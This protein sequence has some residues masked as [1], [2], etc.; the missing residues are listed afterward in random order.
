MGFSGKNIPAFLDR[1]TNIRSDY[2]R[3]AEFILVVEK[4][5]AFMRLVEDKFYNK[6]PCIIITVRPASPGRVM[7]LKI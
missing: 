2:D 6:Y 3:P 7:V 1:V 5:A 4:D